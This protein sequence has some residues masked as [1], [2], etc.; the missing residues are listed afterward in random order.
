MLPTDKRK[1]IN[2]LFQRLHK[3]EAYPGTGIGLAIV[4]KGMER[5]GGTVGVQSALGQ[6]SCFYIDLRLAND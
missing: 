4:R 6:G 5:M 1:V 3:P 2:C